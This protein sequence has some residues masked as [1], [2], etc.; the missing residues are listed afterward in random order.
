M[1]NVRG[2]G[3]FVE[4]GG[5]VSPDSDT[6]PAHASDSA[7]DAVVEHRS[8]Q[9]TEHVRRWLAG[10]TRSTAGGRGAE[11]GGEAYTERGATSL[12][13]VLKEDPPF[14]FACELYQISRS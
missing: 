7:A 5:G 1:I 9:T 14:S 8:G 2:G 10:V 6:A 12:A 3:E 11:V 13:T 4:V